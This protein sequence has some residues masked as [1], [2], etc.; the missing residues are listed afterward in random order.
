MQSTA[1]FD[2]GTWD[3]EK[4]G[5]SGG[6]EW[7]GEADSTG[8]DIEALLKM[9]GLTVASYPS[10]MCLRNA[11]ARCVVLCA[12][13]GSDL[14]LEEKQALK[15]KSKETE[16]TPRSTPS[17]IAGGLFSRPRFLSLSRPCTSHIV[18]SPSSRQ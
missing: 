4:G 8:P 2:T 14:A 1:L 18:F 5:W 16:A 7:G 15:K 12:D 6:S 3:E 17:L 9:R 10:R 13:I 11:I